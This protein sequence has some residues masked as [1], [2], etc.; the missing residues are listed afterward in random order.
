MIPNTSKN[1]HIL[2]MELP[3]SSQSR[4]IEILLAAAARMSKQD[5]FEELSADE[6]TSVVSQR[7]GTFGAALCVA[8][9][10][11]LPPEFRVAS[12]IALIWFFKKLELE[13]KIFP[14]LFYEIFREVQNMVVSLDPEIMTSADS[15]PSLFERNFEIFLQDMKDEYGSK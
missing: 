10:K 4:T 5:G 12:L 9:G 6:L 2:P 1:L 13:G 3:V 15:A 7:R 8:P 11:Q 14:K